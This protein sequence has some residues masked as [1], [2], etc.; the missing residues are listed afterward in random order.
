[1]EGVIMYFSNTRQKLSEL[2]TTFSD[3]ARGVQ[4]RIGILEDL[5]EKA[6][7]LLTCG[8]PLPEE[9][10]NWRIDCVTQAGF[11]WVIEEKDHE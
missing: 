3:D 9:I 7:F 2:D 4:E 5:I 8:N 1:M 10:L 6:E 11:K